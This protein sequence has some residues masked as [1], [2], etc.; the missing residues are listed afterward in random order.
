M[1]LILI[2]IGMLKR[3]DSLTARFLLSDYTLSHQYH[4]LSRGYCYTA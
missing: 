4:L 1:T 2:L 3:S